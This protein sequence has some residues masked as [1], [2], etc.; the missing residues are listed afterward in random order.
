MV[1]KVEGEEEAM[2]YQN[3]TIQV[4]HAPRDN[5]KATDLYQMLRINEPTLDSRCKILDVLCFPNLYPNGLGGM[6]HTREIA[7]NDSDY[8]KTIMQSRLPQFRLNIQFLFY[9]F[10]HATIRQI[11]AGIFHKLKILHPHEKMTA[12]RYLEKIQDQELEGNLTSIFSRL[13]NS[14]QFWIKPR[15]NLNAMTLHYGP[16]TWF[17][18]LSPAEWAW[19]D[20]GEYLRKINSSEMTHMSTGALIAAD[21]ISASRYVNNKFKAML[22]FLTSTDVLGEITH[23]FWRREY[24]GRGMQHFHLQIWV[25][26]API[27]G[28]NR[29]DLY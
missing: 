2:L 18:T 11:N 27:I 5:E 28:V 12:A 21:P 19:D 8:V 1:K 23:Y 7:L 3:Y 16:A 24:Q 14:Q 26:G 13:R 20:L 4:L 10:H 25:K 17:L 9:H 29:D 15:N 6:H 22:E